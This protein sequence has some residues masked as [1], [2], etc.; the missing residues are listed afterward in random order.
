MRYL[1]YDDDDPAAFA[2]AA[3]VFAHQGFG[4]PRSE[5]GPC[6]EKRI[7]FVSGIR[8]SM[9]PSSHVVFLSVGFVMRCYE[10]TE[11]NMSGLNVHTIKLLA[12]TI[13]LNHR[14]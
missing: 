2:P 1:G 5:V 14:C 10:V 12:S 4:S 13:G 8:D 11:Y 6:F 9:G 3:A 7:L